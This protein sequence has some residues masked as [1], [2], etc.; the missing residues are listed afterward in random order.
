MDG[1]QEKYEHDSAITQ[2]SEK[3]D[4]LAH[5][6]TLS[7]TLGQVSAMRVGAL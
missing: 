6:D 7:R 2:S 1:G 4:K 5:G 3:R